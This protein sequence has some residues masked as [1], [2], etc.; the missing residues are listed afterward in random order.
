MNLRVFKDFFGTENPESVARDF[1]QLEQEPP[2]LEHTLRRSNR[3]SKPV[4]PM[5]VNQN[6]FFRS[7]AC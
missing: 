1:D 5:L 4:E 6:I 3:T 2:T 7:N